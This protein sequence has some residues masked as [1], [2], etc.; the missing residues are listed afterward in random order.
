M[1]GGGTE[2]V[3][4]VLANHFV[5]DN[6]K[7]TI[8][9]TASNRIEYDLDS[10]IEVIQLGEA[11]GGRLS[12]R[13]LRI[14]KLRNYFRKNKDTVYLS[15]GTETNMFAILSALF[16]KRK[17]IVSERNDP[18]ECT[19]AKKRD[20]LYPFARGFIFQTQDAMDYFPE[21]IRKKGM[22]IPNPVSEKVPERYEGERRKE[23]VAVGRLEAQKN[24]KL[25]LEAFADFVNLMPDFTLK[26]YGKGYL[27]QDL[28]NYA[29]ELGIAKSV[30]FA[31][32]TKDVLEQIKDSY[33]Y[34][35]SSDYEGISNSLLEAMVLG[36]PVISTD[37]PIGG[38]RMLINDHENG[39][40][41]PVGDSKV[42]SEVM[43]ELAE[44]KEL[45]ERISIEA[46]KLR[47]SYSVKRIVDMWQKMINMV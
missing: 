28:Q 7:V 44:D 4:A 9:M 16:M 36:L 35:L 14:F 10:G 8:L 19:F 33:M 30:I 11:T 39:I 43:K 31:D 46:A 42:L 37:C 13:L 6:N 23:I 32:F 26:I 24:H 1:V 27:K 2:R 40:L 25:L 12:G 20:M 21:S 34:V 5:K 17:L 15:F 3:I 38:S 22:V 47:E 29:A 18:N 45:A 41:V